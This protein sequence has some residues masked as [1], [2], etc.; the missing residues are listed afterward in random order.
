M[1]IAD[2]TPFTYGRP[3]IEGELA[4]GWLDG[5]PI[6]SQG[7]LEPKRVR[8]LVIERLVF[9]AGHLQ[10]GHEAVDGHPPMHLLRWSN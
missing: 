7:V 9:A 2:L 1:R 4:V 6:E 5:D 10:S 8:R 3:V